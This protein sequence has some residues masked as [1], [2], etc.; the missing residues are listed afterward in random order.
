MPLSCVIVPKNAT[1][2]ILLLEAARSGAGYPVRHQTSLYY[3]VTFLLHF[4]YL[5]AHLWI[6]EYFSCLLLLLSTSRCATR[7]AC[8]PSPSRQP[9]PPGAST[10]SPPYI[11]QPW[12]FFFK[13]ITS[14]QE[15]LRYV[16]TLCEYVKI[17]IKNDKTQRSIRQWRIMPD[18]YIAIYFSVQPME[19]LVELSPGS[20]LLIVNK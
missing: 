4:L 12:C 17:I 18:C 11:I 16:L 14:H 20:A 2:K 7:P 19:I 5:Q 8:C 3:I 9:T 13:T 15:T 1:F 10:L 6:V